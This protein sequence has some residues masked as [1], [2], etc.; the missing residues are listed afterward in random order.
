[1]APRCVVERDMEDSK[2]SMLLLRRLRTSKKLLRREIPKDAPNLN[3]HDHGG[4]G[5]CCI[6]I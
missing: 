1:M 2:G 6:L 5:S 3:H 4:M